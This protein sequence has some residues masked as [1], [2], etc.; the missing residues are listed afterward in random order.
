MAGI[1]K[2]GLFWC[3]VQPAA[4]HGGSSS[5]IQCLSC[6][7]QQRCHQIQHEA[8]GRADSQLQRLW[9]REILNTRRA[10]FGTWFWFCSLQYDFNQSSALFPIFTFKADV[11][12]WPEKSP[13]VYECKRVHPAALSVACYNQTDRSSSF[14][15]LNMCT[16]N[17]KYCDRCGTTKLIA[18]L[19][20]DFT[21]LSLLW[22]DCFRDGTTCNH[23]QSVSV[24]KATDGVKLATSRPSTAHADRSK[25]GLLHK[26]WQSCLW[27]TVKWHMHI[28]I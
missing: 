5:A 12:L 17:I 28:T 11:I 9:S 10:V 18:T 22:S 14:Y 13:N 21:E 16:R 23:S 4:W 27:L 8:P 7:I 20:K 2:A 15:K 1:Q 19:C 24:P 25:W 6:T 3:A 26:Q